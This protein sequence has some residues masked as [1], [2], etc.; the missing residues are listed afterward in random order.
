MF[1]ESSTLLV[2]PLAWFWLFL[3]IKALT[4][5]CQPLGEVE[6]CLH[7][8]PITG[9]CINCLYFNTLSPSRTALAISLRSRA[10]AWLPDSTAASAAAAAANL[11]LVFLAGGPFLLMSL[12]D[13]KLATSLTAHFGYC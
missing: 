13:Y 4:W 3:A 1:E 9:C 11:D 2:R 6:E 10:L 7:C 5:D 8:S 12:L